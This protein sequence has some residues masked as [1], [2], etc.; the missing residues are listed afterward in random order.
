MMYKNSRIWKNLIGQLTR[1][2]LLITLLTYGRATWKR[3]SN[4][5]NSEVTVFV[6][7]VKDNSHVSTPQ[8]SRTCEVRRSLVDR[9]PQ[10]GTN[11]SP[12]LKDVFLSNGNVEVSKSFLCNRINLCQTLPYEPPP[13][14]WIP[15]SATTTQVNNQLYVVEKLDPMNR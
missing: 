9:T 4:L 1:M 5:A 3:D 7:V 15:Y 2:L 14:R 13:Q 10:G 6:F 8:S 11:C 12:L